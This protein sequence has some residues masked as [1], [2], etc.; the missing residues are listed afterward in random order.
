MTDSVK[1]QVANELHGLTNGEDTSSGAAVHDSWRHVIPE[2]LRDEPCLSRFKDIGALAKSYVAAQKLIGAERIAV[3]KSEDEASWQQLYE[4]LGR[5]ATPE[6]YKF[7]EDDSVGADPAIEKW[8]RSTAH[9][10]GLT[11]KQAASMK[12]A[13]DDL[14]QEHRK[15]QEVKQAEARLTFERDMRREWGSAFEQKHGAAVRAV[16]RFAN[17]EVVEQLE[18]MMGSSAALKFFSSVGEAIGEDRI[19][20]G[21]Y[22]GFGLDPGQ[23][24]AQLDALHRDS[25]ATEALLDR[26]HPRHVEFRDLR[27]KLYRHAYPED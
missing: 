25:Q 9:R 7:K 2:N 12:T 19:E 22:H 10:I 27:R 18:M 6:D 15:E 3:P 21:G 1:A 26:D 11:G 13:W 17:E 16:R 8:F 4:R 23:A 5:P 24:R 14:T 20:G